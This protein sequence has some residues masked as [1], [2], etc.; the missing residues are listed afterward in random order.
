[1]ACIHVRKKM[2]DARIK[3]GKRH[4]LMGYCKWYAHLVKCRLVRRAATRDLDW[5]AVRAVYCSITV[6]T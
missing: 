6:A 1:M 5:L 2:L 4:F 3:V